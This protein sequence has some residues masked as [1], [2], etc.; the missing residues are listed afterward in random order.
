MGLASWWRTDVDAQRLAKLR[1]RAQARARKGRGQDVPPGRGHM[2][3]PSAG[4]RAQ[5]GQVEHR[6]GAGTSVR[7]G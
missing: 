4:S 2:D 1:R 7:E 6:S 5:A 3:V